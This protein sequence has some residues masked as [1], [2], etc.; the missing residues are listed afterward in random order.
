MGSARR[1]ARIRNCLQKF[2]AHFA[3]PR[4]SSGGRDE[5]FRTPC[6]SEADVLST[7]QAFTNR[8]V[9]ESK[10]DSW[11]LQRYLFYLLE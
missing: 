10:P 4:S 7:L 1:E 5:F 2:R 11:T 6:L 9:S 8:V 3:K